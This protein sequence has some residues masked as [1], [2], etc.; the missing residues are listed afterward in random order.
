M[1]NN[2]TYLNIFYTVFIILFVLFLLLFYV[3]SV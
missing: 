1:I 2:S 3:K